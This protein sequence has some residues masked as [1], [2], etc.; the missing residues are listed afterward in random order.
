MLVILRGLYQHY[1][2]NFQR[3]RPKPPQGHP[4]V[5]QPQLAVLEMALVVTVQL[6]VLLQLRQEMG[7]TEMQHLVKVEQQPQTTLLGLEH[8][9]NPVPLG[10]V[11]K[12]NP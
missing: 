2:V 9:L 4:L 6:E 3:L 11:D 10:Q 7:K 12:M 5:Q 8:L 1:L